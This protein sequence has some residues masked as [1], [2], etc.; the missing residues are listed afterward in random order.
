VPGPQQS[1][2]VARSRALNQRRTRVNRILTYTGRAQAGE[3]LGATHTFYDG[4]APPE[5]VVHGVNPGPPEFPNLCVLPVI[6][7]VSPNLFVTDLLTEVTFAVTYDQPDPT[8]T[9]EMHV[10]GTPAS[11]LVLL[12]KAPIVVGGVTVGNTFTF[13]L[14][15]ALIPAYYTLT[16]GRALIPECRSVIARAIKLEV[17]CV[18]PSI[19]D[20]SPAS[21]F[22]QPAFPET[23][24]VV[25]ITY[26]DPLADDLILFSPTVGAPPEVLSQ[27]FLPGVGVELGLSLWGV[28]ANTFNITLRRADD[29]SGCFFTL[30]DAFAIEVCPIVISSVDSGVPKAPGTTGNM[31]SIFGTGFLSGPVAVGIFRTF[32]IEVPPFIVAV[33]LDAPTVVVVDDTQINI[34]WD[35]TVDGDPAPTGNY[36]LTV[37]RTDTGPCNDTELGSIAILSLDD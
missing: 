6:R 18:E 32:F 7:E 33:F 23:A 13:D 5:D 22:E 1:I 34:V 14:A 8:D 10:D 26:N 16:I 29:P 3:Y 28:E 35:A 19:T 2:R 36:N 12:S 21:I 30:L 15:G 4:D 20:V 31:A 25:T 9:V 37:G 27:T 24:K 11:R 17:D